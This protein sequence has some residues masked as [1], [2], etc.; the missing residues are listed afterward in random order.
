MTSNLGSDYLLQGNTKENQAKVMELLKQ[1]FK[2]EFLNRIDE[3]VMFNSL[4]KDVVGKIVTKFLDD[5]KAHL[6]SQGVNL[7]YGPEVVKKIAD[8]SYDP[9]Y[10]ARPIRRYIQKYIETP[11]AAAIIGGTISKDCRLVV[12]GDDFFFE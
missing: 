11:L 5:L 9:L 4:T 6:S 2:P 7:T 12:K 10:G 8:D 1:K 3:I